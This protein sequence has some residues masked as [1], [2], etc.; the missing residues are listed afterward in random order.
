LLLYFGRRET[1][2]AAGRGRLS[3]LGHDSLRPSTSDPV[4]V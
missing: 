2:A 4:S 1:V 3:R